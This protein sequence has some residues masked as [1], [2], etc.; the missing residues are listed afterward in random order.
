MLGRRETIVEF[1]KECFAIFTD[2]CRYPRPNQPNKLRETN[3]KAKKAKPA[4]SQGDDETTNSKRAMPT[5]TPTIKTIFPICAF[6]LGKTSGRKAFLAPQSIAR[7]AHSSHKSVE[8]ASVLSI[9]YG[10]CCLKVPIRDDLGQK[11]NQWP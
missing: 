8:N 5:R 10:Q 6:P 4:R 1:H 9:R 3:P 7:A 11:R 2:S